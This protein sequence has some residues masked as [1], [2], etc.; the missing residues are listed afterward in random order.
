MLGLAWGCGGPRHEPPPSHRRDASVADASIADA[1]A[2]RADAGRADDEDDEDG[3]SDEDGGADPASGAALTSASFGAPVQVASG[4]ALAEGPLWDP[5][6]ESLWFTDVTPSVVHTLSAD[7]EVGVLLEDTH[8]ANGLAFDVDG[9]LIL[10]Q[11]GGAPGH[12]ARRNA[13]GELEQL[14]PKGSKLHTPDDVIVRSDGTIYFSDG[15]FPPI[16]TFDLSALPVYAL[17]P[18][19]DELLDVGRVL[20]PNGIELSPDE[21]ALYVDAYFAGTVTRF[22]LAA[23]GSTSNPVV[24]T[25]GL[26]TPDSLCVDVQG[27]LYVG[28]STGLQVLAPDG[29]PLASIPVPAGRAVTN[30]AFGGADGKTLYATA[31]SSVWKLERM[32]FAGLDWKV[33]KQ[34]VKCAR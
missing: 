12:I 14:D 17:R 2:S 10:A 32:P 21:K 9:S 33:N 7:G 31:W 29:T 27:N 18:G 5:C 6:T 19:A 28:V 26:S 34:R 11:M 25:T 23:D 16:G 8:N 15:N 22:D 4:F 13:D 24:I 30:C 1:S 20:G 3:G